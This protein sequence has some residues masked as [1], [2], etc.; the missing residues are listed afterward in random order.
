MTLLAPQ[1]T[2]ATIVRTVLRLVLGAF[3]LLAGISHLTVNREAFLAQV[4][5]WLPLEGD[6]VVVASGVV[7]I[8]LGAALLA[9]GRFRVQVGWIVAAFFVAI[10]PGNISQLVTQTDSFGL[11]TDLDR[12][13]RLLFQPVLVLWA[14]WSTGAWK[15][16]R[17]YR[18][19]RRTDGGN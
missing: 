14:L 8:I 11:N 17:E 16:W 18:T 4:P 9:L 5:T 6:F 13:I 12:T 7:E 1:K 15:A 3:L 10:F 19:G 2:R